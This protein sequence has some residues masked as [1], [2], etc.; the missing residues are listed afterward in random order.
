VAGCYGIG[1]GGSHGERRN[2]KTSP[3]QQINGCHEDSDTLFALVIAQNELSISTA[4]SR[5]V[6]ADSIN[7]FLNSPGENIPSVTTDLL[8][9]NTISVV[10]TILF[11]MVMRAQ[12]FYMSE[13]FEKRRDC[14]GYILWKDNRVVKQK[15]IR[16]GR[17]LKIVVFT[18]G[19]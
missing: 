19:L 11:A 18:L 2:A 17:S 7:R 3:R 14:A 10:W 13:L 4:A 12:L 8:H 15:A 16:E 9:R 6:A 5:A 1:H